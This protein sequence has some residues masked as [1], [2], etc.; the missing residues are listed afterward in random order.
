MESGN[1]QMSVTRVYTA[2]WNDPGF[3]IES[4]K[5]RNYVDL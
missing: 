2:M 4:K 1:A 5:L 3:P